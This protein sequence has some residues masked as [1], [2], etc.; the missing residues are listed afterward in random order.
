MKRFWRGDCKI[1]RISIMRDS[2]IPLM[3]VSRQYMSIRQELNSVVMNVLE[4]GNY[5]NGENVK[6][7]E[8]E[9]SEYMG[10]NYAVGVGNGTD[11]LVI[12]LRALGIGQGD[13]VITCALTFYAT[14]EAI[15]SVGATPVFVDC[16]NDTYVIDAALIEQKITLSTKAIIPVQLYG[17]CAEMEKICRI[18]KKHNLYVIEDVAQ[19]AGASYHGKKAGTWGDIACVSFFPTKNLGAAGD[20]GIILTNDEGLAKKCRAFRVHGSGTDGLYTYNA[21]H[22]MQVPFQQDF[23]N[24]QPKYFNY[25]VGYNSRLDEIQAA[26]LRVKL[27]KLDE[28]N[29]RRREIAKQYSRQIASRSITHPKVSDNAE[30]IFYVYVICLER[31]DE[32]RDYL[33]TMGIGTGVYFPIPLHLQKVFE[34]LGYRKGDMP[35]AEY[36][37]EHSLAIPMFPEL[38]C[39]EIARIIDAVNQFA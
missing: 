35:N 12:A 5:I 23:G 10:V 29:A 1:E 21:E 33:E 32:L 15:A 26:I 4:S 27:K 31:R 14:A 11:A 6:S 25:V 3:N 24:N 20:G 19:A 16:T 7:F 39:D 22:E 9:F 34:Y 30:H 37:A 18:A 28:W 17:Q 38:E 2:R 36:V 13:E 8:K